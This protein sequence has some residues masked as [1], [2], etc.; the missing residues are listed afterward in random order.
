V[1]VPGLEH[2]RGSVLGWVDMA[3]WFILVHA[4]GDH[5]R[6]SKAFHVTM[7]MGQVYS[8]QEDLDQD[9]FDVAW[10]VVL[11]HIIV[12]PSL[13]GRNQWHQRR[14]CGGC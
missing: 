4:A 7:H 10:L 1:H 11:L 2:A 12:Q 13:G 14:W 3:L 9:G 5:V 6:H 8:M